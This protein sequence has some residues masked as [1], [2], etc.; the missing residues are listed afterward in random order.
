MAT[1]NHRA[2]HARRNELARERGFKSYAEQRKVME[3]ASDSEEI[4]LINPE[5]LR[6]DRSEDLAMARTHYDAFKRNPSDYGPDSAKA[7]WFVEYVGLMSYKEWAEHY[8]NGVREYRKVRRA[9]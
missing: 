8:P 7:K 9:A 5:P 1:R 4:E 3:Y 2:V 6:V